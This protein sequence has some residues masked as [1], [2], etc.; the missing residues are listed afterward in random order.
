MKH[1][2]GINHEEMTM[3]DVLAME[4]FDLPSVN[5]VIKGEVVRVTNQ[6]VTV[7]I[8]GA[9]EGTIYLNELALE[10]IESAKDVVKVGDIIKAMIKK[11]DDEQILL[12]RRALLEYQRFQELKDAFEKG[13]T[14]EAKVARAVKGGLIVNIGMEAFLPANMIDVKYVSDLEQY[15]GQTIQVRIVEF[16][17]RNRKIKVSRK[18]VVAEQLKMA[19]EEQFSTL[20]VGEVVE[21]TVVRIEKYGAFVRFGALEGLVH[22]SEIS[23]LPVEKV[24]DVLAID[25]GVKAKVI[26]VEGT[27]L[28]LSIKAV[29]PTPFEVF[30]SAHQVGDIVEGEVVRLMDFGAFVEVAKGIE[31]LV[32]L[33]E[34]S[35]DH[36]AKLEDVVSEGKRVSV[37]ILSVDHE[38]HRLAL[39]IKK[40]EEDPW[41]VF[42]HQVGDVIKGSVTN[43]TDLGAFIKVAPY[44]EGLCHYTETSWNPNV[45]LASLVNVGD[46][47]EVKIISLD[48]KKH[49][50]GLSLRQ[51]KSN[52]WTEVSFKV[53]DVVT[54]TVESTNDRGAFIVVCE[55][56]V[57]FLPMNQ[58]TEKRITRV[59]DALT[60]GQEVDV[61]VLRFEPN[62]FKL[63]LSIRRIKEDAEREEY[64]K[65]M[66]QQEKVE[67]ETLGD[68][69]GE[70]LKNLL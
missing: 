29:L 15:V 61:K 8:H 54:G 56:V 35:W 48:A 60:I 41:V 12:S 44:I 4:N 26:K 31:G 25:Q 63:E 16:N 32:H 30:T 53:G 65:Y 6:E 42:S 10:K 36:K 11:V 52:P 28:Q 51:V 19:R 13:E 7:D 47:V 23:H 64:N 17:V 58:I 38:N 20:A 50:L 24:E 40:V 34:L 39:S 49:R 69:F 14:L 45:K 3:G 62:Q 5:D 68:L 66:E 37:R 67:N 43:I 70:A 46:E 55:D 27:K 2:D 21:G 22:I 59:E 1:F 9:T 18:I 57:G 33:S